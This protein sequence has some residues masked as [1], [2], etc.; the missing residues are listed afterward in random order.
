MKNTKKRE[1]QESKTNIKKN[2]RRNKRR[3]KITKRKY[4]IRSLDPKMR[5]NSITDRPPSE[6]K[7]FKRTYTIRSLSNYNQGAEEKDSNDH[8]CLE[9]EIDEKISKNFVVS[10]DF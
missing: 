3:R 6:L 9:E 10:F 2:R 8:T 1:K 5:L 4:Y 7:L